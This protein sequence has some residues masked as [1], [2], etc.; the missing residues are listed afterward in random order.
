M[1]K[2]LVPILDVDTDRMTPVDYMLPPVGKSVDWKA[3]AG[4]TPDDELHVVFES[5]ELSVV[6]EIHPVFVPERLKA[7][8]G[9][10][11]MA[12]VGA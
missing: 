5:E 11:Q 6:D 10:L 12:S 7:G 4:W 3:S 9:M 1:S 2:K 8:F